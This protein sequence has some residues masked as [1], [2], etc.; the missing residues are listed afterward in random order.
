MTDATPSPLQQSAERNIAPVIARPRKGLSGAAAAVGIIAAG[1]ILFGVLDARRRSLSAP[2]VDNRL[3]QPAAAEALPPPLYIPPEPQ[4][5]FAYAVPI[6]PPHRVSQPLHESRPPGP[7]AAPQPR[8]QSPVQ[9]AEYLPST[10]V[11]RPQIQRNAGAPM[12]LDTARQDDSTAGGE[13]STGNARGD[14]RG[15][16]VRARAGVMANRSTTVPQGTIV[17]AV[18]ETALDSSSAGFARAL[19]QRD[20]RGFDGTRILIPR[21]SRLIGE[22]HSAAS[23]GQKRAF[24]SWVR[25]IRPDGGTIALGSPATDPVGKGGV[26]AK[27]DSHF[28]ERFSG[29]ILQSALDVGINL[30]ARSA[31]G[32]TVLALPGSFSGSGQAVAPAQMPPTLSV[33]QGAS[34]SVFVARDL[35]FTDIED[36]P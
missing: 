34:V 21:G 14:S 30:A 1:A 23:A 27:V 33:R 25:L 2:A 4:A 22:Y 36:K 19:V 13:G 15:A 3:P 7:V 5:A 28:F 6:I 35:D 32:S 31:N 16:A 20:I 8:Y 24:I 17:P 26:K 10:A 9:Q 29:T 11:A 12:L 18:L